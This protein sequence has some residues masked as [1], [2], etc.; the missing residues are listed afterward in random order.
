VHRAGHRGLPELQESLDDDKVLFGLLRLSFPRGDGAPV[1]KYAFIHWVGPTTPTV[2][3]ARW[4]TKVDQAATKF[5]EGAS[6]T[7]RMTAHEHEDLDVE[8]ILTDLHRLTYDAKDQEADQFTKEG[9]LSWLSQEVSEIEE[10][11]YM[12]RFNYLR[13]LKHTETIAAPIKPS[14]VDTVERNIVSRL[15]TNIETQEVSR[16]SLVVA[17]EVSR[18]FGCGTRSGQ[19]VIGCGARTPSHT[20][21][22]GWFQRGRRRRIRTTRCYGEN[23]S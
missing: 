7:L 5:R 8:K 15:K 22:H 2:R 4:N 20:H 19:I 1:V 14:A 6:L 12:K 23:C 18:P 17:Q 16:S 13:A 21:K 11:T 9:Y 3:R 10:G